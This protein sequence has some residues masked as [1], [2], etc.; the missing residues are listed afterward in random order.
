MVV[1]SV[2]LAAT[3][4]VLVLPFRLATHP[5]ARRPTPVARSSPIAVR[6]TARARPTYLTRSYRAPPALVRPG[7]AGVLRIPSLH[8]RI[9]VDAVGLDGTAMAVPNDPARVGW[10]NSTAKPGDLV[11]ASVLAGHVSDTHDRPGALARLHRIR[12]GAE[13]TWTDTRS[14]VFRYRVVTLR[15]FPRD[16][17]LP[18][19]VFAT[20]GPQVLHLVTCAERVSTSGGG[21]H[22]RANLVVSAV[23]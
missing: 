3:T 12:S 1:A 6:P 5:E 17:G 10:L 13:I 8:L 15:T 21:F 4:A 7:A 23:R 11:G 2:S 18:A 20:D 16:R 9:P 22:Y 19:S 14:R